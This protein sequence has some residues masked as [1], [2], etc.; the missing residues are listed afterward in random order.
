M[1]DLAAEP[2]TFNVGFYPTFTGPEILIEIGLGN[3]G[4][5]GELTYKSLII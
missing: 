5:F 4:E 3:C 1:F 2:N